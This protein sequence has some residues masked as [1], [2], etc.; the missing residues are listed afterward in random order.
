MYARISVY[1][2]RGIPLDVASCIPA[3][4]LAMVFFGFRVEF[5][6]NSMASFVVRQV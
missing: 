4:H 3:F 6:L 2:F 5:V 1:C